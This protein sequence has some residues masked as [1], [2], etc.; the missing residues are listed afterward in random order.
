MEM[1][2]MDGSTWVA[3]RREEEPRRL[4]LARII[5]AVSVWRDRARQRC[6]LAAL[7]E[8]DLRDIG[9]TRVEQRGECAKPFWRP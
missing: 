6:L 3:R 8:R 1:V 5:D 4:A 2:R 9:V 7:S